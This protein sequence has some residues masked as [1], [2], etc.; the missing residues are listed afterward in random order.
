MASIPAHAER[1]F[2]GVIFDV[3]QWQQEM[4]DGSRA[5]FE[6]LKRPNTV[7]VIPVDGAGNVFYSWQEQP[8]KPPFLGL[9]GGRADSADEAPLETARRELLEEAGL[10]AAAWVEWHSFN[11]AS[12]IDW[13]VYYF[14]AKGCRTVA[15]QALD[16][17]ERIEIR[18][19]PLDVFVREIVPNAAF[20]E[21]ELRHRILSAFNQPEAD[22]LKALLS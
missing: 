6:M 15:G 11:P 22:N 7:V 1:V 4:F 9:F 5:T 14:I 16:G 8:G 3:Y 10:E 13:T 18:K 17:G 2:R 21:P 20:R 19:A 12:K